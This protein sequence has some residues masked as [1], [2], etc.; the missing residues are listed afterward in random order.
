MR[1]RETMRDKFKNKQKPDYIFV[2]QNTCWLKRRQ[3][4]TIHLHAMTRQDSEDQDSENV[5]FS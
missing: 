3:D 4:K 5:L 2:L 1:N